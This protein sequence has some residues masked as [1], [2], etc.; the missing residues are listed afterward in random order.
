MK[1]QINDLENK[2][3]DLVVRINNAEENLTN[4]VNVKNVIYVNFIKTTIK[5]Y[6]YLINENVKISAISII[7]I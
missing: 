5:Q 7:F 4:N 3:N 2:I 6:Y 1:T